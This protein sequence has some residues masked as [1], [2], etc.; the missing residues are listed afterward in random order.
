MCC[1]S[2]DINKYLNCIQLT[3][4]V[5]YWSG[6]LII[7][8]KFLDRDSIVFCQHFQLLSYYEMNTR[9]KLT[10][11]FFIIRWIIFWH[12]TDKI[13]L[14]YLVI[15]TCY[16][17]LYVLT[18]NTN[19]NSRYQ[20]SMMIIQILLF[21]LISFQSI[22]FVLKAF[23]VIDGGFEDGAFIWLTNV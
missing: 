10:L 19:L 18:N 6:L 3:F 2:G 7:E 5:N 20:P 12:S 22:Y 21:L 23:Y 1:L 16:Q 8:I 13:Y 11:I 4:L 17:M 14:R 9:K 15:A